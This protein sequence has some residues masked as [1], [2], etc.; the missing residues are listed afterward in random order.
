MAKLFFKRRSQMADKRRKYC[1][2]IDGERGAW[3]GCGQ[4]L[5][6]ELPAGHHEAT[7][8][9]DWNES[10]PLEI[11]VSPERHQLVEVNHR[12]TG[13]RACA[14][15]FLAA[16]SRCLAAFR[17]VHF[18]LW[19]AGSTVPSNSGSERL[20]AL[21]AGSL[22]LPRGD[23]EPRCNSRTVPGITWSRSQAVRSPAGATAAVPVLD[24]VDDDRRSHRG[25]PRVDRTESRMAR[26][27]NSVPNPSRRSHGNGA[28]LPRTRGARDSG[29]YAIGRGPSE[30][31]EVSAARCRDSAECGQSRRASRLPRRDETEVRAGCLPVQSLRRSGSSAAPLAVAAG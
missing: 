9:I 6:I 29:S 25:D 22:A 1:I 23:R 24:P 16:A 8:R 13:W 19:G 3:I 30:R 10:R 12:L 2:V 26:Q 11:D 21:R 28:T 31:R 14:I 4:T 20:L 15:G 27:A 17:G 5:A 7:M 18:K